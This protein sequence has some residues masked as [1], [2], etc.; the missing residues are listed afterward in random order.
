MPGR[1]TPG[2]VRML[3]LGGGDARA[4]V[5]GGDDHVGLALGLASLHI[6]VI[7]L[8]GL[9]R[10]ASTGESSISM[11]CVVGTIL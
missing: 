5:A 8:L 3:E 9:L 6:T 1:L 4:G 11:T 10:I 2:S 7:E